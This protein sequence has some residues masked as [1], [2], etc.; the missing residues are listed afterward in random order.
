M[1]GYCEAEDC[2]GPNV[3]D[4]YMFRGE[5]PADDRSVWLCEEHRP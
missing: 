2:D 3:V 1:M 4:L 5:T